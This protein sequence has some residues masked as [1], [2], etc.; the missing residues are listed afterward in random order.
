MVCSQNLVAGRGSWPVVGHGGANTLSIKAASGPV[1]AKVRPRNGPVAGVVRL[2][3]LL[4]SLQVP[5][6]RGSF[7]ESEFPSAVANHGGNPSIRSFPFFFF[8][9]VR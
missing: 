8:C 3:W 6:G 1:P 9:L 4:M 7:F 2:T 5:P